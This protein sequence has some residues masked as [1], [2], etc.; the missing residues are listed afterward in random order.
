MR[1]KVERTERSRAGIQGVSTLVIIVNSSRASR[2]TGKR[3]PLCALGG[4]VTACVSHRGLTAALC[5]S[6]FLL[7]TSVIYGHRCFF[8]SLRVRSRSRSRASQQ[9][10]SSARFRRIISMRYIFLR[11][12]RNCEECEVSDKGQQARYCRSI[13]QSR[14]YSRERTDRMNR[15]SALS[16]KIARE[17]LSFLIW[18]SL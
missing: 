3:K 10:C 1:S 11:R 15:S 4:K 8:P 7:A 18:R 9:T 2:G 12:F 17:S 14:I 5:Q 16:C 6:E 13:N